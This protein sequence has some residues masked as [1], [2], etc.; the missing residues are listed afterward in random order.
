MKKLLLSFLLCVASI[1]A[2][3]AAPTDESLHR[4]F[5]ITQTPKLL[6]GTMAQLKT[7][8]QQTLLKT[9]NF[10]QLSTEEKLRAKPFFDLYMEKMDKVVRSQ[11]D[12]ERLKNK[13]AAIY[14]DLFTQEEIDALIAFYSSPAGQ[15]YVTK[16]PVANQK[17]SAAITQEIGPIKQQAEKLAAESVVNFNAPSGS[18]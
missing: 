5:E 18:K 13:Y 12:W 10:P 7:L 1:A 8:A 9:F 14:R 11:L 15:A 3:A 6:D 16:M 17:I 4:F 2:N